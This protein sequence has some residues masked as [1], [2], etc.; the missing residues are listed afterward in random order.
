MMFGGST[1]SLLTLLNKIDYEKYD[2]TLC[3]YEKGNLIDNVNK[4]VKII[5][6]KK[7]KI[8]RI[9]MFLY[10]IFALKLFMLFFKVLFSKVKNKRNYI[11]VGLTQI[12]A[13]YR[14]KKSKQVDTNYDYIIGYLEFWANEYA[15]LQNKF[16]KKIYWI[17]SDYLKSNMNYIFDKK[18]F[19][20]AYKIVFVAD[21]CVNN[22]NLITNN[23]YINKT[24]KIENMF[25]SDCIR[26]NGKR[27]VN[28]YKFFEDLTFV[29]PMRMEY[30]TKGLDRCLLVAKEL[31]KRNINFQWLFIG[32]GT[33]L[34]RFELELRENNLENYVICLGKKQNPYKY[35]SRARAIIMLSR[36]EGKPMVVREAQILGKACIVTN[37]SSANS[38]IKNME[39]GIICDNDDLFSVNQVIKYMLND[40]LI[41]QIEYNLADYDFNNEQEIMKLDKILS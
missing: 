4:Q 14:A 25:N 34:N 35:M 6:V 11:K 5:Y 2:V 24:I 17:H 28:D 22:F 36:Y 19:D 10:S 1:S 8:N 13:K 32:D 7:K 15:S 38:Q 26:T 23:K 21:E 16:T 40:K 3:L 27:N 39:T 30:Y 41:K 9:N 29:S 12:G 20:N 31:K 18:K 33:D 37:Y